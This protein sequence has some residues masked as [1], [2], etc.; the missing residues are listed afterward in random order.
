[1]TE[2]FEPIAI[3]GMAGRFP[4]AADTG[5]FW[6]NLRDGREAV[7]FL[8]DAE[9]LAN[10]VTPRQLADPAYV[11]AVS[12]APDLDAVD[13]GFFGFTPRDAEICDPQLRVFLEV[14]HATFE[15][16]GYDPHRIAD[17]VGVFGATG[18][19]RYADMYVTRSPRYAKEPINLWTLNNI[20]YLSTLVSYKFNLRGPSYTLATACSSSLSAIHLACQSLRLGECDYALAGGSTLVLPYGHGYYWAPGGVRSPDGHCP[21]C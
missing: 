13:A 3:I 2:L 10:G 5:Q 8:S 17:S 21:R 12:V 15:A 9:L 1:M 7:T 18:A 4:G 19:S 20:D 16:A 11:K 14:A 6:E